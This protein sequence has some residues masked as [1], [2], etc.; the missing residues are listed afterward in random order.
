MNTD[1]DELEIIYKKI[2]Q[3]SVQITELIDRKIYSELITFINKKKLLYNDADI[4][5]QKVKTKGLDTSP[6]HDICQ[7]I[8]N[9]EQANIVA[10]NQI[11]EDVRQELTKT[12]ANTKILNAYL[13][14]DSPKGNILDFIE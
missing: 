14:N 11:K 13:K 3:I 1:I 7:K 2:F 12:S 9:L 5:V 6:L 4:L 8:Y 10:L